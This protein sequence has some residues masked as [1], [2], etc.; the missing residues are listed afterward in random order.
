[1]CARL[2]WQY[3]ESPS[4]AS[5]VCALCLY[6]RCGTSNQIKKV[7]V[8]K[9]RCA[10]CQKVYKSKG[11]LKLDTVRKHDESD[12]IG[13]RTEDSED[14][15]LFSY[16]LVL[17]TT[18]KWQH[19]SFSKKRTYFPGCCLKSCKFII[20][21]IWLDVPHLTNEHRTQDCIAS[22]RGQV[23]SDNGFPA[24]FINNFCKELNSKVDAQSQEK[25]FIQHIT[26]I[27]F[28]I[29]WYNWKI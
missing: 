9:F 17:V 14:S 18:L 2:E 10:L 12:N 16:V 25:S 3:A 15:S 13:D 27:W 29:S 23:Y 8:G 19:K 21:F 6:V 1:M 22:W 24:D 28:I 5:D 11:G 20:Y 4:S 26:H 7:E